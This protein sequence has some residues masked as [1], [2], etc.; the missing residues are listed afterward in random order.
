[1]LVGGAMSFK[2]KSVETLFPT[3]LVICEVE[4]AARL[5][6]AL[7]AEIGERRRTE[8]SPRRS[9]RHGWQSRKDFFDRPEPAHRELAEAIA[10]LIAQATKR[11]V[12]G[13]DFAKLD[14]TLEGWANVNPAGSYNAPHDHPGAFW[15]GAY[16]VAM[17]DQS[18]DD[19]DGGA[20]EFLSHRPGTIFS[21]MMP[22]PMTS[23]KLRLYPTAGTALLFPATVTHW[24]FPHQAP[25][26]RVTVAF[27][28]QFRPRR[29]SAAPRRS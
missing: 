9:N 20:I 28:A 7:L 21:A 11:L 17:P 23:E 6:G 5:N 29:A 26:E 14:M 15:S 3:P 2:L 27:N 1:M 24:V 12:P 16:Y 13:A 22:A 25:E 8:K 10:K 19:P 4:D 18:A